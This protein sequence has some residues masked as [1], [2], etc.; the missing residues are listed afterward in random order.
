M[1]GEQQRM[2]T[3]KCVSWYQPAHQTI[4]VHQIIGEQETQKCIDICM[5]VPP[6]KPAI[7]QIINVYVNKICITRV[8]VRTDTV[9][10]C[11][12][13]DVKVLYVA[14]L[15][16]QPVHAV[17]KTRV[18]FAVE[19]CISGARCGMDADASVAVE[20]VDYSCI[21]EWHGHKKKHCKPEC[22]P[23]KSDCTRIFDVSVVLKVIVRVMADREI[24]VCNDVW[25]NPKG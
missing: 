20:S 8:E 25:V 14:C 7:E 17:E 23:C 19:T 16:Q 6:R 2:I 11:G 21:R 10:V 12:H 5:K 4:V 24:I 3:Q 18:K 22:D 1:S 9:V 15:P 13:F